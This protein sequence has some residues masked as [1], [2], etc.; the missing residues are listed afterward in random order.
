[1]KESEKGALITWVLC[2]SG[3][4]F[5]NT[6]FNVA[7]NILPIRQ[8]I[9]AVSSSVS[10]DRCGLQSSTD[11][12]QLKV[13]ELNISADTCRISALMLHLNGQKTDTLA[14]NHIQIPDASIIIL[15]V[16]SVSHS[17]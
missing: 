11:F 8:Y 3:K 10:A 2:R 9:S 7:I 13:E 1:M 16:F 14:T 15:Q 4:S 12:F 17:S 5:Q 6:K